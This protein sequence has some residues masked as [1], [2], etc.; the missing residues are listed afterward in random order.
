M[1]IRLSTPLHHLPAGTML[2]GKY[3]IVQ[4]LGEG[5]FGITYK[6]IDTLLDMPVAIKEYYPNG[7]ANRYSPKSLSV[8]L[9]EENIADYFNEWKEKY[10]AEAR[11]LARLNDIKGIVNVRDF[12]EE[13]GTAYIVME[14]LNGKTL[15]Q[16][17]DKD[18]VFEAEKIA[19]LMIPL[20]NSLNK[21]HE[22]GLIHRDISPDNIMYMTDG[23]LKLYDFGAARDY[24]VQSQQTLSVMLKPGYAPQEQYRSKGNQG[25]WTDIYAICA[26]MYFCITGIVPDDSL[27]RVFKDELKLP[28]ELGISIPAYIEEALIKGMAIKSEE[29]FRTTLELA[30]ALAGEPK[31]SGS[32]ELNVVQNESKIFIQPVSSKTAVM[33][34]ANSVKSANKTA[35]MPSTASVKSANKTAVMPSANSAESANKTA[36]MPRVNLTKP[37]TVK[38]PPEKSV[39]EKS[40]SANGKKVMVAVIFASIAA[41]AASA[42]LLT[43][44][45]TRS[46]EKSSAELSE[47]SE[48]T[49][50]F[51][52][53]DGKT[54]A[55]AGGTIE[56]IGKNYTVRN[57]ELSFD[58]IESILNNQINSLVFESCSFSSGA[59]DA[60]NSRTSEDLKT[61]KFTDCT[62]ADF[63]AIDLTQYPFLEQLCLTNSGFGGSEFDKYDA[64]SGIKFFELHQ[65]EITDFSFLDKLN[66]AKTISLSCDSFN[67]DAD[68]FVGNKNLTSLR[69]GGYSK[70]AKMS[71]SAVQSLA[72]ASEL[73]H[74]MLENIDV[75]AQNEAALEEILP[76]LERLEELYLPNCNLSS[77][78]LVKNCRNLKALS[79]NGNNLKNLDALQRLIHLRKISFAE[80]GLEDI[81]GLENCT[82]LQFVYLAKN[83]LA[84]ISVLNKSCQTLLAVDISDNS[85]LGGKL[86]CVENWRELRQLSIS[87]TGDYGKEMVLNSSKLWLLLAQNCGLK[88]IMVNSDKLTFADVSH[89]LLQS[90]SELSALNRAG[91]LIASHNSFSKAE[92]IRGNTIFLSGNDISQISVNTAEGS[93]GT[94][95]FDYSNSVSEEQLK[96]IARIFGTVIINDVPLDKQV[97]YEEIFSYKIIFDENREQSSKKTEH[98]I[99]ERKADLMLKSSFLES[100]PLVAEVGSPSDL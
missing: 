73:Y 81:G 93:A 24:S 78:N 97:S 46:G 53:E 30:Q 68:S 99:E 31:I 59:S 43:S 70:P 29:R 60:F 18:G 12:F 27:Q 63:G 28:S 72:G 55:L 79:A 44:N 67:G 42:V 20:L 23:T 83:N 8:T 92:K 76:S 96:E 94:I 57:A 86:H 4:S 37:Q 6:G 88:S 54:A 14:Y 2:N 3:K 7:Y 75:S 1:I 69:L 87:N 89:N 22:Q 10:L 38:K 11:T 40:S 90:E 71:E 13:N 98:L 51:L 50:G 17:V 34:S 62:N 100:F 61:L 74:L 49:T 85:Q 41:L 91:V 45:L 95:S 66:G 58:D 56:R 84:D 21:I 32:I 35:V 16:C 9:T 5:G 19:K 77:M 80:C 48:I 15:K 65:A 39:A 47:S 33:P 64:L 26:T 52:V 36:V 82:Q 25:P